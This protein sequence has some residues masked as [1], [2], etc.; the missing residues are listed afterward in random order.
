LDDIVIPEYIILETEKYFTVSQYNIGDLINIKR[1]GFKNGT[2][3]KVSEYINRPDGHIYKTPL[4]ETNGNSVFNKIYIKVLQNQQNDG[5]YQLD[6][7]I[8]DLKNYIN[9]GGNQVGK[10]YGTLINVN[11]QPSI[12]FEITKIE[13]LSSKMNMQNSQVI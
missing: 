12:I 8:T 7:S 13:P 10:V 9:N 3:S 5:S 1:F 2:N 11:L 6:Q 4:S